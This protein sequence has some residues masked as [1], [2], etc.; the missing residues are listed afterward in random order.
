MTNY[1]T[2]P[3]GCKTELVQL[4]VILS[5]SQAVEGGTQDSEWAFWLRRP[6]I[7]P[8]PQDPALLQLLPVPADGSVLGAASGRASSGK[9]GESFLLWAGPPHGGGKLRAVLSLQDLTHKHTHTMKA[10]TKRREH[11]HPFDNM[12]ACK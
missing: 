5:L 11:L 9:Y 4:P 10:K 12:S 7:L 6:F 1:V 2:R 8:L 3:P